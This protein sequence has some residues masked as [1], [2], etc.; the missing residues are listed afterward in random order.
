MVQ[1]MECHSTMFLDAL[2]EEVIRQD[3]KSHFISE[4]TTLGY[5]TSED[6]IQ[7]VYDWFLTGDYHSRDAAQAYKDA[8]VKEL[9]FDVDKVFT[10]TPTYVLLRPMA[11]AYEIDRDPKLYE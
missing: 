5:G 11:A 8:L 7:Y 4:V 1:G 9:N 3:D 10:I 6:T 2:P